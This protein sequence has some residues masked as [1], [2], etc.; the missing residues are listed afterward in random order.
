MLQSLLADRFQLR[1]HREMRELP[2]YFLAVGKNGPAFRE[3]P[4]GAT[5]R[6]M[7]GVAGRKQTL[8][9]SLASMEA[10]AKDIHSSFFIDRPV[11]DKTGLTGLYDIRL[12]ATPEFRLRDGDEPGDVDIFSAVQSQLGLKLE[13]RKTDIEVLVV[14]HIEKPSAN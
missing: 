1:F 2:V 13:S 4:S 3:T 10:L 7:H 9:L 8:D 11:L 6:A 5:R 12:A 14:D